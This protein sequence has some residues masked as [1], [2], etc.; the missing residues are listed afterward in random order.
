MEDVR[1]G[2]TRRDLLKVGAA[3]GGAAAGFS[4]LDPNLMEALAWGPRC[5]QLKDIEHF[6]IF[7]KVER[8]DGEVNFRFRGFDA[9]VGVEHRIKMLECLFEPIVLYRGH[10]RPGRWVVRRFLTHTNSLTPEII[11]IKFRGF[12]AI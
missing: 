11:C 5:G 10:L 2:L 8:V 6:V 3:A 1:N 12:G 7:S 4:A 9:A